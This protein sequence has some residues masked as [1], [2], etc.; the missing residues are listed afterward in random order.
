LNHDYSKNKLWEGG[1]PG[2]KFTH[3][4]KYYGMEEKCDFTIAPSKAALNLNR[5][6]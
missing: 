4:V 3:T 2:K 6:L 5:N 1:E